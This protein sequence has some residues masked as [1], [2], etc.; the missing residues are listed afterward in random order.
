MKK[1]TPQSSPFESHKTD[2]HN[3]AA[4]L[5][6]LVGLALV[7]L[8]LT[9]VT[10]AAEPAELPLIFN[11]ADLAGWNVPTPN[12]FWK[13]VDGVLVGENDGKL[14]GHVLRTEKS[15]Q[16]FVLE[17]EVRWS[18]EIDSGIIFR[19]PD[20]QLQFGVSRSLKRD[21]TGSFYTGGEV[22]YPE[23]G[24][25]KGVEGLVKPGDWNKVRLEAQGSTFTVWL[26]GKQVTRFVDTSFNQAA[27]IGLQIHPGL[28]MKV[29][30]RNIRAKADKS[31]TR[32]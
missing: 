23:A 19:R 20:L 17:L 6:M 10:G 15:Y 7:V 8:S 30:Y 32:H 9:S 14:T 12:P 25:A 3:S 11:G 5:K 22:K 26:N 28:K 29:E 16:D 24:R 27:P 4:R 2:A 1:H 13:V 21:M 31:T 18:G